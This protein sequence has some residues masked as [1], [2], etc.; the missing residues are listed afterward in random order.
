MYQLENDTT[1][2][3]LNDCT[4]SIENIETASIYSQYVSYTESMKQKPLS[5]NK[6][7]RRLKELGYTTKVKTSNNCSIR[8]Y[9]K[10]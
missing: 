2:S 4:H 8:V 9:V 5:K 6:F 3:F 7:T 1:L 10:E